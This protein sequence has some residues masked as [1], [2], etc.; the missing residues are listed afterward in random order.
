M[1]DQNANEKAITDARIQIA[2]LEVDVMHL[3]KSVEELKESNR[4]QTEKIDQVLLALS[5]A[6]GG[7][8]TLML[9][10]GAA[11]TIGALATWAFSQLGK[12]VT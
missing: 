12:S 2:R 10:G 1:T 8:R 11:S 9:V 4:E 3:T 7:W 5:S 6:R